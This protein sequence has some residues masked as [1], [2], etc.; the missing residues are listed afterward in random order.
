MRRNRSTQTGRK[1]VQTVANRPR[2]AASSRVARKVS[3]KRQALLD[4]AITLFNARG[5]S[6]TSLAD[7]AETLGLARASIYHYV[8][9]RS[10]LVFQ[11]Y[12]RSCEVTAQDLA[13]AEEA[14]TGIEKVTEYIRLALTADRK[15]LAVL[16]EI[17]S[18]MPEH[19]EIVGRAD[20]RNTA[21][22]REYVH[23]G[24]ADG[25]IRSC[26][27]EIAT[28]AIIG[29]L[30]WAQLL[31]HWSFG[32]NVK[33]LRRR[34]R[35]AM[36]ELLTDGLTVSSGYDFDCTLRASAFLPTVENVFNREE[37]SAAKLDM[38]LAVASRLF[39]RYGIAATSINTIADAL[40]V[41][42]GALYHHLKDKPDLIVRCY[43]RS[44]D[45]YDKFAAAAQNNGNDGL[46]SA[47]INAHLNIQAQVDK[48]S[49]LMPQPG[50][51]SVPQGKRG[52]FKK[53]A[54]AENRTLARLLQSGVDQG[55]ARPCDTRLVTHICA[56]AFGWLPK[57]LPD[58]RMDDPMRIADEICGLLARGLAA[59]RCPAP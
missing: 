18:L 38:A 29:M 37:F 27:P 15:A 46:E 8:D 45:L 13:L 9:D 54:A 35:D 4:G 36:I 34:A 39:N 43:E 30:A 50:F 5:I 16:S 23:R 7:V 22:L 55:V 52:R 17:P 14:E 3:L 58:D 12:L 49:P 20:N 11:C 48:V 59:D 40:G 42:K 21:T 2:D 53:R 28:Q 41:T 33:V 31:P 51:E 57:W 24:M 26:D 10:D 44:F 19:R 56:G 25:G 1:P 6:G 32:R 47:L